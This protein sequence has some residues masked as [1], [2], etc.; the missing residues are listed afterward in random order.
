M[1]VKFAARKAAA[2]SSCAGTWRTPAAG[3]GS[4]G[5]TIRQD[6]IRSQ[7][8][9]HNATAWPQHAA[10][11]LQNSRLLRGRI[12]HVERSPQ[13]DA[14]SSCII[15]WNGC[16]EVIAE[17]MFPGDFLGCRLRSLGRR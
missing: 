1:A 16:R 4:C 15:Q 5:A 2:N 13:I 6:C 7:S 14:I 3:P 8:V 10:N 17:M 9:N 12:A 11:F